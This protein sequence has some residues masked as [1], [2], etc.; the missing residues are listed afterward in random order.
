MHSY[1]FSFIPH[2]FL[3]FFL[4]N[5]IHREPF[6]SGAFQNYKTNLTHNEPTFFHTL[7]WNSCNFICFLIIHKEFHFI[8]S[9]TQLNYRTESLYNILSHL[10][11]NY[12]GAFSTSL[13]QK[14]QPHRVGVPL[15]SH[16]QFMWD[17][18]SSQIQP[19]ILDSNA[20]GIKLGL[21][22]VPGPRLTVRPYG[23]CINK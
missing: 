22:L 16:I 19:T 20:D 21:S 18:S 11:G 1:K 6:Y 7:I 8:N 5:T 3:H 10:K 12:T 23:S 4:Q 2:T 17:D 9:G 14:P 15:W 13:N